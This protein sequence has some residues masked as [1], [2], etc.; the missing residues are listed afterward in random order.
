MVDYV[1][2]HVKANG[3]T[4]PKVFK[5]WKLEL[6][7]RETRRL[8]KTH[9]LRPITTRVYYPGVHRVELQVNGK[10]VAEAAFTLSRPSL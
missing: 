5:G 7:P 3:S 2:H 10:V 4:S 9:S 8:E 1:V 6:G